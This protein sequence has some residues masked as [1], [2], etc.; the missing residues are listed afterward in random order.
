MTI[1]TPP[2]IAV[3]LSVG[4]ITASEL[5]RTPLFVWNQ[6]ESVPIGLYVLRPS[7]APRLGDLAAI[8]LPLDWSDWMIERGYLGVDSL[9]LKR[10]AATAGMVVCRDGL[11]VSVNGTIIAMAA[12]TDRNGLPLP[13]WTGC[14]TLGPEEVFLL[15]AHVDDSLDGRYFGTINAVQIVGQAL[16]LWTTGG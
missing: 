8:Q 14:V 11:A 9:L 3:C 5:D 12:E 1:A 10:V 16:P 2:L 15:N 4:L 13:S 7:I 6:S